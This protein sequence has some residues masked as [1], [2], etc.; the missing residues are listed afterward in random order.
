MIAIDHRSS[1]LCVSKSS[2][3]LVLDKIKFQTLK[4]NK[5]KGERYCKQT[6]KTMIKLMFNWFL[7]LIA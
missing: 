7:V 2:G 3:C 4:T 6:K 5:F 1:K